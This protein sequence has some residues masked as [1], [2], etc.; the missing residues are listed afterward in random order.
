M[1]DFK[2]NALERFIIRNHT[3]IR[4]ILYVVFLV[5][6]IIIVPI[7]V[8]RDIP[9]PAVFGAAMLLVIPVVLIDMLATFKFLKIEREV[10]ESL[11][12]QTALDRSEKMLAVFKPTQLD[13]IGTATL[14]KATALYDMGRH[15]EAKDCIH[16]FLDACDVKKA[17][18]SQMAQN[19]TLLAIMALCDY[20]FREFE[21][22]KSRIERCMSDSSKSSKM[23]FERNNI[24][25]ELDFDYA[26]YSAEEY[27]EALEVKAIMRPETKNG[28]TVPENKRSKLSYVSAY[29]M[30]FEYFKRLNMQE[31]AHY[32]ARKLQRLANGQFECYREAKEYLDNE[33][34]V[35]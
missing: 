28:K 15:G 9:F 18:F 27:D 6:I 19:H 1:K 35:D 23:V 11:D 16:N 25:G 8:D 2:I 12:L 3:A 4:R 7:T 31:K 5:L 24:I 33:N 29:S 20:D 32:Y 13:Y 30:L 17:P 22:Q 21:F 34:I 14:L 26:L 10:N